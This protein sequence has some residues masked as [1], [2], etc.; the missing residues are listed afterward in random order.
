MSNTDD[1]N[2]RAT[3]SGLQPCCAVQKCDPSI[4][5]D[6]TGHINDRYFT[7]LLV[8]AFQERHSCKP[9]MENEFEAAQTG[10]RMCKTPALFAGHACR[11]R[12]QAS[13]SEAYQSGYDTRVVPLWVAALR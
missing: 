12:R 6:A 9:L 5:R 11:A 2:P 1:V 4:G 3:S 8:N 7:G 10:D 13:A